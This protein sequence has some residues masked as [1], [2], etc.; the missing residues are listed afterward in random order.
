MRRDLYLAPMSLL[1]AA[2]CYYGGGD[3]HQWQGNNPSQDGGNLAAD[4]CK[5][6]QTDLDCGGTDNAQ[7]ISSNGNYCLCYNA[8]CSIS[9]CATACNSGNDCPAS[10]DCYDLTSYPDGGGI[11]LGTVC[12]PINEV[13]SNEPADAGSGASYYCQPCQ[14]DTDC[15]GTDNAA[16]ISSNG[17]YCLCADANCDTGYCATA[18]SSNVTCSADA[19]CESVSNYPD[20]GGGTLGNAC[21][22]ASGVCGSTPADAGVPVD[23]GTVPVDAG[24][25]DAGSPTDAGPGGNAFALQYAASFGYVETW[26]AQ[27]LTAQ[28]TPGGYWDI[29][30]PTS[31]VPSRVITLSQ[32]LDPSV[33]QVLFSAGIGA[34]S[35]GTATSFS[36]EGNGGTA[37]LTGAFTATLNGS[38]CTTGIWSDPR[39]ASYGCAALIDCTAAATPDAGVNDAGA[40]TVDAG[41]QEPVDAGVTDAGM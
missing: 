14:S 16:G 29:S 25:N 6:C 19:L 32:T 40:T 4:Y 7:G 26:E 30:Q 1:L 23:A 31:Y 2:G 20:G 37:T 15:G 27:F 24:S 8:D 38:A 22:P 17:N 3:G 21:Q 11:D 41:T 36:C 10:A 33:T 28:Q 18:C 9:G 5:P 13:C 12:E 34:Q 35:G 39:G